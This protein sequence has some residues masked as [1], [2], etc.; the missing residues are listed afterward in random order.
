MFS[1][2]GAT[3]VAPL[4]AD[5]NFLLSINQKWNFFY[6]SKSD[7]ACAVAVAKREFVCFF[8]PLL[9]S[10]W[11]LKKGP[12][13]KNG[14]IML[15][16]SNTQKGSLSNW[17]KTLEDAPLH[18]SKKIII[19]SFCILQATLPLSLLCT[20]VWLR[21]GCTVGVEQRLSRLLPVGQP[22]LWFCRDSGHL[23]V[24]TSIRWVCTGACF[25]FSKELPEI[26]S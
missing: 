5:N 24:W 22:R 9:L 6:H 12:R 3:T 25:G 18:L 15:A 11:F 21:G 19:T 8:P 13:S 20:D 10:F 14:E 2:N 26:L 1:F 23:D 17:M 16:S 7:A 4:I